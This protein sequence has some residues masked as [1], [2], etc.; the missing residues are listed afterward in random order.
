MARHDGIRWHAALDGVRWHAALDGARL[1]LVDFDGP[2]V[3]LLPDPEHLLLARRLAGWCSERTGVAWSAAAADHV[4]VLRE[5]HARHP[6]LAAEAEALATEVEVAAAGVRAAYP[7]AIRTLHTWLAHG[8]RLA[9]VSNNAEEAV[10]RVLAGAGLHDGRESG[11]TV[12]A[13]RPGRIAELKPRPDL[14]L[15]AMAGHGAGCADTAMLGDTISDM[16]AA[17]AAGVRAIGITGETATHDRAAELRA[18]GAVTVLDQLADLLH[19]PPF[20]G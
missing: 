3:R 6:E 7:H 16:Q 12:Q 18:A 4:Q 1:L 17:N 10:R 8:G 13:R 2:L 11:V 19:A 15:A 9:V 5:I 20:T 14:L